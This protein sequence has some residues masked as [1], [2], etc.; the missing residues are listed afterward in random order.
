MKSFFNKFFCNHK[1]NSFGNAVTVYDADEGDK[2]L[3]ICKKCGKRALISVNSKK[4]N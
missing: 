4:L 1:W 2:V 3:C